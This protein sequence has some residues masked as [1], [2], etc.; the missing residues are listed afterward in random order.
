[1]ILPF[2]FTHSIFLMIKQEIQ[3]SGLPLC[4]RKAW[5]IDLVILLTTS[6]EKPCWKIEFPDRA[7]H[8]TGLDIDNYLYFQRIGGSDLC[9]KLLVLYAI[10]WQSTCCHIKEEL[11]SL[12][13]QQI[14]LKYRAQSTEIRT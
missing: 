14:L 8:Q 2:I 10:L 9:R 3:I 6:F 13:E 5:T 12:L 4:Q 7:I 11:Y 1:M